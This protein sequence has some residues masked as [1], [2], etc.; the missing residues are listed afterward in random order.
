MFRL[1]IRVKQLNERAWVWQVMER[2]EEIEKLRPMG[3][4]QADEPPDWVYQVV[5]PIVG[6]SHPKLTRNSLR[7]WT[8]RDLGYFLGRQSS[9]DDVLCGEVPLSELIVEE[10]V[11]YS[12]AHE[13]ALGLSSNPAWQKAQKQLAPNIRK[14]RVI[15]R[16]FVDEVIIDARQRPHVESTAF[17]KAFGEATTVN[18]TDFD[19]RKVGVGERIAWVML[20]YWPQISKFESVSQLHR[21]L[22]DA[23]RPT[24]V[25]IT[26]KRVEKLCSRIGLK[27]KGR[28]RPKKTRIQTNASSAS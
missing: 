13:K 23:A 27:F 17:L 19:N 8:A 9:L 22:S 1:Q 7:K 24:G 12:V 3:S 26:L 14:W 21:F 28:G 16:K 10:A 20:V 4:L 15:F 5:K 18:D 25:V 2:L 11:T 6:M